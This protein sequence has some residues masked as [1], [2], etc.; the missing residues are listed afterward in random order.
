[1]TAADVALWMKQAG[2]GDLSQALAE[3][4]AEHFGVGE[5]TVYRRLKQARE[6]GLL[7]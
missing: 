6:S 5:S 4:I 3:K 1:M 2:V 7:P